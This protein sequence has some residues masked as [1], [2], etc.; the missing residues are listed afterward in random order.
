MRKLQRMGMAVGLSLMAL[1]MLGMLT[2]SPSQ[3]APPAG[4]LAAPGDCVVTSTL[5]SGP[6]SLRQCM[7]DLQAGAT[8]TFDTAIFPPTSPVTITILDSLPYISRDN[9]T[10]DAG[11]GV[12]LVDAIVGGNTYIFNTIDVYLPIIVKQR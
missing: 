6:G 8:I 7:L 2:G 10:I 5:D 1:A 12:A 11:P 3:A 9:V 4:P